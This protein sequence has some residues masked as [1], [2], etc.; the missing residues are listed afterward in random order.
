[1]Q[2]TIN[3]PFRRKAISGFHVIE[4]K[5][6]HTDSL[7]EAKII[8]RLVRHGFSGHKWRRYRFGITASVFRYTPDVHLSILHDNINRRALVEFKPNATI[9]FS[10]KARLRMLASAHFF[11]DALCFLYIEKTKQWYLI[12]RGGKLLR[13][14]EPTP[15]IV[16]VAKLPRP[17]TMIPVVG[18]YG[19]VYWERPGMFLL[20]KTGDGIQ[21]V[22]EEIF[23]RPGRRK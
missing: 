16:P 12:E 9:E 6:V 22:V 19:R 10:K 18:A 8:Q 2:K 15:G 4:G 14:S 3:A 17:R 13:T 7:M 1:M 11:K 20:R 23:G 21:F 5:F